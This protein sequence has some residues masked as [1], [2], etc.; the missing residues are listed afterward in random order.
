MGSVCCSC[1]KNVDDGGVVCSLRCA[2]SRCLRILGIVARLREL[3]VPEEALKPI[4][5]HAHQVVG[6]FWSASLAPSEEA[7]LA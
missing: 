7:H 6:E 3:S 4:V 5:A 2:Q 1:N